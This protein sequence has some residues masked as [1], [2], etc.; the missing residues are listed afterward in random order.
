MFALLLALATVPAA[1]DEQVEALV[2]KVQ[3]HY[4]ALDGFEAEFTQRYERRLLRK[5]I[6]ESGR[7]VV[8][9]PGRMR[10]EYQMPEEKLFVTD[11]SRSYFYLPMEKQ[12]MVSHHPRG[13]MGMGQGSPFELLAGT[14]RMTDSFAFFSSKQEPQRGGVMLHL[15]P[16]SHHEEFE[17]VEIEVSPETGE[18]LRVVLIDAQRNHTEFIFENIRRNID[19]PES[20]FRF[21]IPSGV[22]VVVHSDE[23]GDDP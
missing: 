4:D 21:T 12:V 2:E 9:K 16:T 10:W 19:L 15:E 8:K 22:E 20:L 13:A 3:A 23:P 14:G 5:T 1:Q 7:V 18:L 6:E 17:E 11:G